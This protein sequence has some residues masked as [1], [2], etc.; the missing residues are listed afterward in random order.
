M[1]RC[2]GRCFVLCGLPSSFAP[3]LRVRELLWG[4]RMHNTGE[5]AGSVQ[6]FDAEQ[7][8][9]GAVCASAA[10]GSYFGIKCLTD[11]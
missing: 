10:Q 1:P 6:M 8:K 5:S 2:C 7:C 3:F 4:F 9:L 11:S